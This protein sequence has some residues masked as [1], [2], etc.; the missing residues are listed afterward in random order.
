MANPWFKLYGVEMLADPKYQRLN[1]GERSCW[2]TLLCLGAMDNGMVKHCEEQYLITH[3]GI[4][5]MDI[6]KYQGILMKFE[7]LG[8][9]MKGRDE[10]GSEYIQIKNWQKRQEVY[11]E[12]RDRVKRWREKQSLVTP[13]TLRSNARIEENRIDKKRIE[14]TASKRGTE[15]G[16]ADKRESGDISELLKKYPRRV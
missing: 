10:I 15:Y 14:N 2:V 8:L 4:D 9:I 6:S 12:S 5:I 11:S 1:A 3:S 13:V 16:N 7:M